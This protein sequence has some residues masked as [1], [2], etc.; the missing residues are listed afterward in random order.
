MILSGSAA[1]PVST[2]LRFIF[3]LL[4]PNLAYYLRVDNLEKKSFN[5]FVE[6]VKK[7]I[8]E[9]RQ[10]NY[11][12]DDFIDLMED[13]L[14]ESKIVDDNEIERF[15]VSNAL[16]LFFVGNDT[17]SGALALIMLNL[18]LHQEVQEK[19]YNEIKDAIDDFGG[20]VNLDFNTLSNLKYT[21]KVIKE[22][23]RLWG[24]DFFDRKC[25]KNYYIPELD[26]TV[27]KG[28]HVSIAAG[29]I[30]KDEKNFPGDPLAF[31]PDSHFESDNFFIPNFIGFGHGPRSCIGMRL[32]YT[33]IRT[34]LV[35]TIYNFKVVPGLKTKKNWKFEPRIP[36]GIDKNEIF[37]K[38]QR[39]NI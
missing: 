31:D 4:F 30:M 37:V 10:N 9:R 32:A 15:I 25:T 26:F 33:M 38:L 21:D 22:S 20:Q 24:L 28:M 14:K 13:T 3:L 39:R 11:R 7:S 19:L 8:K 36:G 1:P 5:F 18:A 29:H 35:H 16:L 2:I 6:I 34:A 12:R 17:T 27:P 23:I